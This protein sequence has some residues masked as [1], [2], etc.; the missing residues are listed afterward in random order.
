VRLRISTKSGAIFSDDM[1]IVTGKAACAIAK[2]NAILA[3]IPRGVYRPAYKKA[4]EIIAGTAQTLSANRTKAIDAFTRF[5]V[6]P[7][8]I[9][10]ALGIEGEGDMK[11]THIATLRAM[12]STL[13]NGESTVEEMFGKSEPDH[14]V[15]EN[16]L[17]DDPANKTDAPG[18]EPGAP[19]AAGEEAGAEPSDA[20]A[21]P[22]ADA[23][24]ALEPGNR[25]EDEKLLDAARAKSLEGRRSFDAWFTR[26]RLEQI[27]ALNHHMPDL[28]SAARKADG[29]T[30]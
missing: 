24:D 4:R 17:A 7:D 25:T 26:L 19:Q 8:Q 29:K 18:A 10:D 11:L 3:G 1:I 27:D 22:A 9:F 12:F 21:A 15:I 14:K 2:R 28:L 16:P 6:T 30:A 23:G 13:K 5:G 20:S